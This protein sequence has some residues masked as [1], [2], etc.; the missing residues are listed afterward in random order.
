MKTIYWSNFYG[1]TGTTT[2]MLAT[3][4]L[5]DI[6]YG[7]KSIQLHTKLRL[8]Q[9]ESALIQKKPRTKPLH[10]EAGL[11]MLIK[12]I[13]AGENT[14]ELLNAY[15]VSL[16]RDYFDRSYG[17]NSGAEEKYMNEVTIYLHEILNLAEE[18][19]ESVFFDAGAVKGSVA[20]KI[21]QEADLLVV[22]LNQNTRVLD[23]YFMN[24]KPDS[25]TIFLIGNYDSKSTLNVQRLIKNYNYINDNNIFVV[26]YNTQIRD[27]VSKSDLISYFYKNIV[28]EIDSENYEFI[29]EMK[30]ISKFINDRK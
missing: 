20:E 13:K 16:F 2:N 30:K 27:V 12:R 22:N 24:H 17:N 15:C 10:K 14:E 21:F 9:K 29:Y 23:D 8:S 1:Q 28:C 25:K 11:D 3:A 18:F 26:P 6:L 4:V 7:Q 5:S 19:Y